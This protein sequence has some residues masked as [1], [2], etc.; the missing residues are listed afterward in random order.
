MNVSISSQKVRVNPKLLG[1]LVV[2]LSLIVMVV[3]LY[4]VGKFHI[5]TEKKGFNQI[6]PTYNNPIYEIDVVISWVDGSDPDHYKKRMTYQ[7]NG[8]METDQA[9]TENRYINYNELKLMKF[10]QD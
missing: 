6:H 3:I 9:N 4:L 10:T 1:L 5:P 7:K 8:V 2:L